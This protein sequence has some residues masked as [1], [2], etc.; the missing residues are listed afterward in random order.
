MS[1]DEPEWAYVIAASSD[2]S[3]RAGKLYHRA[4]PVPKSMDKPRSELGNMIVRS[5]YAVTKTNAPSRKALQDTLHILDAPEKW[6]LNLGAANTRLHTRL[7]NL[8]LFDAQN[9]QVISD[10]GLLPF[11]DSSLDVVVAQE[12]LEH[13]Y[14]PF[15]AIA[16]V[17]RVLKPGG[18]FYC[19]VPFIIGYHPG[20]TDFWRFT[21]ESFSFMFRDPCWEIQEVNPSL[22]HGSG[23][24]RIFVEFMAVTSSAIWGKL[25]QPTK[26]LCAVLFYPLQWFDALIPSTPA[27]DRIPGGYYCVVR[28]K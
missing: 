13:I 22:G 19:Q 7:L 26:G 2:W 24:Y 12:V 4:S 11:K 23:F 3:F 5:C 18:T 17:A 6:G 27:K 8:D 15:S 25:Y 20:P 1:P 9:V 14:D 28:K 16:E 21:R 10:G